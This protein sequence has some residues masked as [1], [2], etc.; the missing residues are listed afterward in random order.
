MKQPFRDW[1]NYKHPPPPLKKK[2]KKKNNTTKVI[3]GE[4]ER[5]TCLW[6]DA[7][8]EIRNLEIGKRIAEE[9]GTYDLKGRCS[10]QWNMWNTLRWGLFNSYRRN[11]EIYFNCYYCIWICLL[12][13]I[14][15]GFLIRKVISNKILNF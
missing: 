5:C 9:I 6:P 7:Q 8:R 11:L 3:D 2:K 10:S 4:I 14:C 12:F 15:V 1:S 13:R